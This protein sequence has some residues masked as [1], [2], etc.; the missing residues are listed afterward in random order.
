M[1]LPGADQAPDDRVREGSD[2]WTSSV[3]RQGKKDMALYNEVTFSTYVR[4]GEAQGGGVC[5]RSGKFQGYSHVILVLAPFGKQA[6]L[7]STTRQACSLP[8]GITPSSAELRRTPPRCGRLQ[9]VEHPPPAAALR[10]GPSPATPAGVAEDGLESKSC[11]QRW[12]TESEQA[13]KVG[14]PFSTSRRELA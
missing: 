7:E 11:C 14:C 5:G 9:K 6:R 1:V 4:P 2:L 12:L 10:C 3:G 13:E 8:S